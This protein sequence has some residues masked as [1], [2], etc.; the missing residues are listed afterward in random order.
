LRVAV[1]CAQLEIGGQETGIVELLRRLDRRQFRPYLYAFR[2]G[3][4]R[5][6]IRSL[7][8]PV[9]VG[10]RRVGPQHAWTDVDGR[11]KVAFRRR[12]ARAFRADRIDVCLVYAWADAVP[13]SREA[14]V[15]AIVERVDGPKLIGWVRDKS[16]CQRIICESQAISRLLRAQRELLRCASVPIAVIP[17]GID[18]TRFDP[19]RYDRARCRRALGLRP[20]EFVVGTVAR[21]TPVK[22]LGHFL[23]AARLLLERI[24]KRTRVRFIIAGPEGGDGDAL[25]KHARALGL[26][27][28]VRFLGSQ[29]GVPRILRAL[30]AFV[31][32]SIQ[33]G[34]PFALLEAMAMGLPVVAT[35][36]DSIAESMSDNGFLVGPLD[37][38]R[39]ALALQ[40]LL[41]HEGLRRQLGRRSRRLAMR[42]S[43]DVMVRRYER[44]LRAAFADGSR[45]TRCRRRVVVMPGHPRTRSL[46]QT[47]PLVA[48]FDG[49]RAKGFD[50]HAL[51]LSDAPRPPATRWPPA[52]R[53]SFSHD[54]NGRRAR[55]VS[56]E[57]I[58]P[59]VL[60]TDC[61]RIVALARKSL[62]GEEIIFMPDPDDQCP[63]R[64]KAVEMA[65]R[66]FVESADER[67]D[68]IGR[69]PKSGRKMRLLPARAA[70][71]FGPVHAAV[72]DADR[73]R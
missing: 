9:V 13:A 28:R 70:D 10:A 11:A 32:T 16:S 1:V 34:L 20:D 8:I 4:L 53:Q 3:P 67:R 57:W 51:L 48:L 17:N 71:R 59:D 5:R 33:E 58:H 54:T 29:S 63:R 44:T 24:G 68:L 72:T 60:V 36:T 7:G 69:S 39:T 15:P 45:Q 41:D 50:A 6:T 22:N 64:A 31:L 46:R 42:H 73:D 23:E 30:D 14:G 18:L 49:L 2:S 65:D 47:R 61:P 43:V 40:D 19:D 55:G 38:L 25:R 66:V 21:L 62:P 26:S 52:R 37:P 12:L 35:Q 27:R 56:L